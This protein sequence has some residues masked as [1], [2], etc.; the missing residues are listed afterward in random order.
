MEETKT[1]AASRK[2]GGGPEGSRVRYGEG[3]RAK[4]IRTKGRQW[5][6]EA[7][8]IF[9][10]ALAASCNV[11]HAAEAAGATVYTV[12]RQRRLRPEF[13]LRWDAALAQGHARL[14]MA[15]VEA[16][17]D[18]LENVD[19]DAERPIPRMTVDQAI[20]IVQLYRGPV[21]GDGA[22]PGRRPRRR[23]LDE[24][25]ASIL[26]KLEAIENARGRDGEG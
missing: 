4:L 25:R 14:E 18:S 9:F 8:I 2:R 12:H 19:F 16:A 17:L 21:R 24:V 15:L 26:K 5:S 6:D 3:G 20:R 23:S 11:R 7:E 13:A 1:P 22:A 10:D